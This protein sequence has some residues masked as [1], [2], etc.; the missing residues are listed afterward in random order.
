MVRMGYPDILDKHTPK[1]WSRRELSFGWTL[2]IWLSYVL[3]KSDHRKVSVENYVLGLEETISRITQQKV[4]ALDFSDDRLTSLLTVLS[5]QDVW[6]SVEDDIAGR[7]VDVYDL[8][9]RTVRCDATTVSGYHKVVDDGIMQFGHSKDDSNLPQF[10][11]MTASLDPMGMPLATDVVSGE[12][13]DSGLYIPIIERINSSLEQQGLLFVGDCKM[14]A[15]QTRLYIAQQQNFYLSPL[16]L[17]GATAKNMKEWIRT[18]IDK[19][20]NDECDD[21]YRE[22]ASG[23]NVLVAYGYEFERELKANI[24][25]QEIVHKERVLVIH[26]PKYAQKQ[27]EGLEQR[28]ITAEKKIM[29]LTPQRGRGKRQITEEAKLLS[30]I[31][32]ILKKYRVEGLL[33]VKYEREVEQKHQ[34][35]GRGRGSANRER[36]LIERIRYQITDVVHNDEDKAGRIQE[37]GWKAFVTNDIKERLPLIDA[38]LNYRNEYRVERI[39]NRLKSRL[40]IAPLFVKRNDQIEGMTY[41]LMLGVKVLSLI[42]FVIRRSLKADKQGLSGLHP[43]NKR[44]RTDN[45]TGER[46]LKAFSK[47]TL[48]IIRDK[49]GSEIARFLTPLSTTQQEIIDRLNFECNAYQQL[50]N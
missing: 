29:M 21:I 9:S 33:N 14:S 1:N 11:L 35:I 23:Q 41:L 10:K 34:Y 17:I 32:T 28:I 20:S 7:S 15:L 24:N 49:S 22:N 19:R 46:V 45:P 8:S 2:T 48:T 38:V 39:F 40:N 26:S 18:G 25:E 27:R 12:K 47:V 6:Q 30:S 42:E 31:T 16:P 44:R 37:F 4:T 5:K 50:V 43:E 13:A 36:R 3:S